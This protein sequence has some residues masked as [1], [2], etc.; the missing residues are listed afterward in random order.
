MDEGDEKNDMDA[1]IMIRICLDYGNC[2]SKN[3]GTNQFRL[4]ILTVT[5]GNNAFEEGAAFYSEKKY[6]YANLLEQIKLLAD[7]LSTAGHEIDDSDLVQ[8]T[9]NGLPVEYESSVTLISASSSSVSITFSEVFDL[10]LTQEK[11]LDI[12]VNDG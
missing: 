9:M 2:Y 3:Q 1:N 10:L 12:Q 4:F 11:R 5:D 7:T 8:T 6:D